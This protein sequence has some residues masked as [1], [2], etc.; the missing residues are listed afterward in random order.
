MSAFFIRTEAIET[1][2]P[3]LFCP[4][5]TVGRVCTLRLRRAFPRPKTQLPLHSITTPI[6]NKHNESE[7]QSQ[8]RHPTN[9]FSSSPPTVDG[10]ESLFNQG[11]MSTN[12]TSNDY[13]YNDRIRL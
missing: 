5:G 6:Y 2:L 8:F 11:T 4:R 12:T 1:R 10:Q 13:L 3:S 9:Q 7:F